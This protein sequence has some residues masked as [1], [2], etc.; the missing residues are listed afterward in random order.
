M[1][2]WLLQKDGTSLR[3]S[4]LEV[5]EVQS[6]RGTDR[7]HIWFLGGQHAL[8]VGVCSRYAEI[9]PSLTPSIWIRIATDHFYGVYV[10]G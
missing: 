9:L 1:A 2:G 10:S 3:Q 7:D 5:F 4:H 8:A 6:R